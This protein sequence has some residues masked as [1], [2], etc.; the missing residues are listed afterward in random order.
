M[1]LLRS[2]NL[3]RPLSPGVD[4]RA[5]RSDTKTRGQHRRVEGGVGV[6]ERMPARQF[7]RPVDRPQAAGRDLQRLGLDSL[8]L[9]RRRCDGQI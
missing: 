9:Q 5:A 6:L 8:N 7:E 3:R 4:R 2:D 1:K